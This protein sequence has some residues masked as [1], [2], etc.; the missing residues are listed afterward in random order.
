MI[1]DDE[2]SDG[3][4]ISWKNSPALSCRPSRTTMF[5]IG[6]PK[7]LTTAGTV[8]AWVDNVDFMYNNVSKGTVTAGMK[9]FSD[10]NERIVIFPDKKKYDYSANTFSTMAAETPAILYA[11]P[12][13]N[14][15]FG[16]YDSKIRVCT[17]GNEE[18]WDTFTPVAP[19]NSYALDWDTE[20]GDF[21]AI[22]SYQ[23]HVEIFKQDYMYEVFN[24]NP[25]YN[26]SRVNKVGCLNNQAWV[27]VGQILYF[28]GRQYVY[29]YSGGVPRPISE[30]LN[31]A[32]TDAVVGGDDRY[33]YCNL[34][35][36]G[37]W[38]LY[39]YD[40]LTGSWAV[41]DD[42]HFLQFTKL[43]GHCYGLASTGEIVQFNSGT[44][45][46]AWSFTTKP[47]TA[48]AFNTKGLNKI[49][50][51]L[52]LDTGTVANL[53]IKL[54]DGEFKM[55]ETFSKSD[56]QSYIVNVRLQP[57]D[58]V[59]IKLDGTGEFMFMGMQLEYWMGRD[60]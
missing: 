36:G 42:I 44:E 19:T 48:S 5:T 23:N 20:G 35:V 18:D 8:L 28:A 31:V 32:Y 12:H 29:A 39:V 50:L 58:R 37:V 4:N 15:I 9:S 30:I 22:A 38:T 59:T 51:N 56:Y 34:S 21:S 16:V 53:Y 41:E 45:T 11:C 27:E 60:G 14:R 33:V 52:D 55:V 17:M 13:N 26:V 43:A 7:A 24:V 1:A 54:D 57:A 47:F 46:I 25:P 49:R 2:L 40:T 6:V 10:L 3:E